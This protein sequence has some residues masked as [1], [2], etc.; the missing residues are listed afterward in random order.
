M[1]VSLGGVKREVGASCGCD[2]HP[3]RPAETSAASA[4]QRAVNLCL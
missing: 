4:P 3:S 2:P 1:D